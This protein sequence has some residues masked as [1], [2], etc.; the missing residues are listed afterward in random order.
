MGEGKQVTGAPSYSANGPRV[1][2]HATSQGGVTLSK[3]KLKLGS[4]SEV[5]ITGLIV[6]GKVPFSSVTITRELRCQCPLQVNDQPRRLIANRR[7]SSFS[8]SG[9]EDYEHVSYVSVDT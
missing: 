6:A 4:A 3:A 8:V 1:P 2:W 9:P 5:G 7:L